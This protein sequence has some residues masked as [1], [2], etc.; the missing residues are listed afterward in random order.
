MLR[1]VHRTFSTPAGD[2]HVLRG[3]DLEVGA[4]E[5]VVVRGPSGS[6]K[7]TLLNVAATID[8]PTSGAV[9][10]AGRAVAGLGDDA[11]ADLRARSVGYVFQSF[12]LLPVLSAAENVE[13]PLRM[14]GTDP[15][16]RTERVTDA[17]ERVGLARH[18]RQR[19]YELSGGQQQRVGVARALVTRPAVLIA[20]EPTG[21]LDSATAEQVMALIADLV[22]TGGVAAVVATHDPALMERADRVLEM[23]EGRLVPA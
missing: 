15:R 19:P 1:D 10:L 4:G 3:L 14:L 18:A 9:E 21:Q 23:H 12:G 16:E 8:A 20:D 17:L 11:L 2:V 6:G 13:V 7:T 5:L 22:H